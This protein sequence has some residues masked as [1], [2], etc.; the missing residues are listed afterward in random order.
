[1]KDPTDIDLDSFRE[2][3]EAEVRELADGFEASIIRFE[4][5]PDDQEIVNE[6][7]RCAH[8]IKGAAATAGMAFLA[9][10]THHLES[11]LDL[12][13]GGKLTADADVFALLYR[14]ADTLELLVADDSE[15]HRAAANAL[16]GE[17]HG[18]CQGHA[19]PD[20][21]DTLEPG[22]FSNAPPAALRA[23]IRVRFEPEHDAYQCGGDPLLALRE[24][25]NAAE[26]CEVRLLDV[27]MPALDEM[28][29]DHA[30]F[31][32]EALIAPGE[33]LNETHVRDAFSF[34]EGVANL[35]VETI[36]PEAVKASLS[37]E[38]G[39]SEPSAAAA[40]SSP[41]SQSTNKSASEQTTIRVATTKI[42][43]VIDLVGELVIA[44]SALRE[45]T[46]DYSPQKATELAEAVLVAE[47]H[48]RELQERVMAVRMI[49]VSALFSRLPRMVRDVSAKLG[50]TLD[51]QVEGADTELDKT[52]I[53]KLTDPLLHLVRNAIDHGI[54]LPEERAAHGKPASATLTVRAFARSGNVFLEVQD[55]GRGIDP[56]KVRAT[57]VKRGLLGAGDYVSD[58]EALRY[59]TMP[60]FSTREEVTDLSGR[61]VGLDVVQKNIEALNGTLSIASEVGI[62]SRFTVRLPLTLTI[63]DGLL[64][65]TGGGT[66]VLPLTDVSHSVRLCNVKHRQLLG[67]ADVIDLPE[68]S[69]PL[70]DLATL[71][72]RERQADPASDLAVIVHCGS[73][74]Y[75]LRVEALLGQAQTVVK[76]LEAHYR[77]VPGI[78]GATILGDGRVALI[79]DGQGLAVAAGLE[80]TSS[81]ILGAAQAAREACILPN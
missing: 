76:S 33:E 18:K 53:E 45:L 5:K 9:E 42:D 25:A 29:P 6:V 21:K 20:P 1:M 69:L 78:M 66:C 75:A 59:L 68:E 71:L 41:A 7:F 37:A 27:D 17:L 23:A 15:E 62:G 74:R 4:G 39:N 34:F 26:S 8:S 35:T 52:L 14:A 31:S 56:E 38:L 49:P 19:A 3:F 28:V 72:G 24:I 13:R 60:G 58:E 57:A 67:S 54:E 77:R 2:A 47:R 46:R 12:L 48:L 43:R 73:H 10:F 22:L 55:D 80:R 50:K 65:S 64:V 32:F 79:L 44:H 81:D 70:L 11:M 51:F 16:M 30:Y 40:A 61:G 36:V 63:V